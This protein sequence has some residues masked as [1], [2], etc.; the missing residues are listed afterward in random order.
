M[1]DAVSDIK[2]TFA[3]PS[4]EHPQYA[5]TTTSTGEVTHRRIGYLNTSG[6]VK[7]FAAKKRPYCIFLR[8]DTDPPAS[9]T[10]DTQDTYSVNG[11]PTAI[12]MIGTGG[13]IAD[14]VL[15][16]GQSPSVGSMVMADA[17][18]GHEGKI[19]AYDGTELAVGQVLRIVTAAS[20]VDGVVR[21][22]CMPPVGL[23]QVEEDL[24]VA[25]NYATLT[26]TPMGAGSLCVERTTGSSTGGT[27]IT[28]SLSAATGEVKFTKA[29]KRLDFYASDAVSAAKVAYLA[30]IP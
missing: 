6:Y 1:T 9:S 13:V 12:L 2:W 21:V 8:N 5:Y 28:L 3:N 29:T 18:T 24:T 15:K 30:I 4:E 22:L 26:Y 17:T 10:Y 23:V 11:K 20:G 19:I 27:R 14:L 7:L 25:S 16:N